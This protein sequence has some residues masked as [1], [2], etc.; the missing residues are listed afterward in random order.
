MRS[1]SDLLKN[2]FNP[3]KGK[4]L[5]YRFIAKFKGESFTGKIKDF[6]DILIVKTDKNNQIIEAYQY[7]L[8]W[9]DLPDADLYKSSCHGLYLKDKL[10]ISD[11]KLVRPW[12]YD[13]E[14]LDDSG[15]VVLP[16]H[17]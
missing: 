7:T 9:T 2:V 8:E 14:Q 15:I 17:R 10:N 11:F 3:I 1:P 13:K 5:V 6:Q 4:Y 16:I 12:Y